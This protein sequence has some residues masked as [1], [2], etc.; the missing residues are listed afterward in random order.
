[1]YAFHLFYLLR[2]YHKYSNFIQLSYSSLLTFM[3][4]GVM[5]DIVCGCELLYEVL[6]PFIIMTLTHTNV[7]MHSL[8][9]IHKN[10]LLLSLRNIHAARCFI[11]MLLIPLYC[12]N[13]KYKWINT[14]VVFDAMRAN[15]LTK[16]LLE[17]NMSI[18][19]ILRV[20]YLLLS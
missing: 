13:M 6:T 12:A 18:M 9:F 3:C 16:Y 4:F 17:N 8:H 11:S 5:Y 15:L 1:M 20:L 14:P 10:P 19:K 7:Y 2:G